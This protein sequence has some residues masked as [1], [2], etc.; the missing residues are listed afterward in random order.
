[1]KEFQLEIIRFIQQFMSPLL[2]QFFE[3]V[4][5][6]GEELLVFVVIAI[7]YY[8]YKKELGKKI[9][10]FLLV[11]LAL[12]NSL[13]F[14]LKLPRPIGEMGVQSIRVETA[15]G[16]SFP[17]GHAQMAATLWPALANIIKKQWFNLIA[18][19]IVVMV[20]LSRV[21]LGV[22]YPSDALV[23]MVVGL[24]VV[25]AGEFL[26]KNYKNETY[27]YGITAVIFL[28]FA[29]IFLFDGDAQM[30]ADFYKVYG[31]LLGVFAAIEYEKKYI[32]FKDTKIWMNRIIRVVLA[33]VLII[34]IKEGVKLF[35]PD[36]FWMDFIRYFLIGLIPIGILP[37][38]FK[39]L[40]L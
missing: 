10:Y 25:I 37:H 21:Y 33:L 40:K 5:Q 11:S 36:T 9:M 17:S 6:F 39:P 8:G 23:G 4:T 24:G 29:F 13:K 26:Y 22:H 20:A 7:I 18:G 34:G 15:T 31:L 19:L 16:Y 32:N 1:M 28:P 27:I 38:L 2:N 35:T 30:A 3:L 14:L 12:N